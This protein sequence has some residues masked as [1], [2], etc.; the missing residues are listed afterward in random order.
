MGYNE[1]KVITALGKGDDV[2][3]NIYRTLSSKKDAVSN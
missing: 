1:D 2:I 3:C